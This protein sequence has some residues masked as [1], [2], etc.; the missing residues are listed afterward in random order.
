MYTLKLLT[1][2]TIDRHRIITVN[3]LVLIY[4]VAMIV[5][6][7]ERES[8]VMA[9]FRINLFKKLKWTPNINVYRAP[10]D[11]T[12]TNSGFIRSMT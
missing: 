4:I 3:K 1:I 8:E 6:Y 5:K 10:G 11:L 2:F 9:P 7:L 12:I